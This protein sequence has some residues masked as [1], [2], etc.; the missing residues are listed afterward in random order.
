MDKLNLLIIIAF[1]QIAF[2]FFYQITFR[3]FYQIAFDF[4]I[5]FLFYNDNIMSEKIK[6][7]K[8]TISGKTKRK[9]CEFHIKHPQISHLDIAAHFN[10]LYNTDIKRITV[11]KILKIK[12]QWLSIITNPIT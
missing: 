3:F 5:K 8:T 9:I 1:G 7:T 4:F 12:E 6:Q 2:R 10:Q 11:S